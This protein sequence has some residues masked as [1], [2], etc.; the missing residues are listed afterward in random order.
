M[1]RVDR[2]GLDEETTA[3]LTA[4]AEAVTEETSAGAEWAAFKAEAPG[5]V[6]ALKDALGRLSAGKCVYCDWLEGTQIEHHWPKSPHPKLNA[7]R[8]TPTRMYAW[9]NLLWSCAICNGFECKGSHMAWDADDAP[10]LMD[11]SRGA[12]DPLRLLDFEV[13]PDSV[14]FGK[15]SAALPP[16]SSDGDRGAY[17]VRRLKLNLRADLLR[18]RRRSIDEFLL[19][20]A[21]IH[22]FGPDFELPEGRSLR[23]RMRSLLA[24]ES[25][26]LG[27]IRQILQRAPDRW[28]RIVALVPEVAELA[29]PWNRPAF[30]PPAG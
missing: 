15:V 25:A 22:E 17:T 10:M 28:T 1:L 19:V 18:E 2:P 20:E 5:A 24:P 13:D 12:Q 11:P 14:D 3:T 4:R 16:G 8:G 6:T 7:G 23:G 30:E 27:P 29:A 9:D 26:H 21:T